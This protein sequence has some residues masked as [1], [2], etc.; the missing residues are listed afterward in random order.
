MRPFVSPPH[1]AELAAELEFLCDLSGLAKFRKF[2]SQALRNLFAEL[3]N[4]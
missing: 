1:R 2:R 3:E 4:I